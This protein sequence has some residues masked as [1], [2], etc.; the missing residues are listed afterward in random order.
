MLPWCVTTVTRYMP[1]GRE[2]CHGACQQWLGCP[3]N[4]VQHFLSAWESEKVVSIKSW[5]TNSCSWQ[6]LIPQD[7]ICQNNN[8]T[9]SC[10]ILSMSGPCVEPPPPPNYF[11]EINNGTFYPPF[12]DFCSEKSLNPVQHKGFWRIVFQYMDVIKWHSIHFYYLL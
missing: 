1:T 3:T 6:H 10:R 4:V 12:Y 9:A 11:S 5:F 7:S 2:C 8:E